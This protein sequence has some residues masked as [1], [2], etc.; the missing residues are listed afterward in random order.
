[1][2]ITKVGQLLVGEIQAMIYN[3]FIK[4]VRSISAEISIRVFYMT[5]S[6]WRYLVYFIQ[7][8]NDSIFITGHKWQ[9]E[10]PHWDTGHKWQEE[11]PRNLDDHVPTQYIYIYI[12]IYNF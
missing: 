6:A 12:Y 3:D 8:E 2:V 7:H 11:K 9:D 10:K 1:M 4:L 5:G